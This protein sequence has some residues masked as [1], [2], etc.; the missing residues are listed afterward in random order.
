M[1]LLFVASQQI[2][3]MNLKIY[4]FECT[5]SNYPPFPGYIDYKT[6]KSP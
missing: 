2:V 1:L 5:I 4:N 3:G 6:E